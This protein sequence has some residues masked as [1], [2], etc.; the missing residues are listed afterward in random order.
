MWWWFVYIAIYLLMLI[1]GLGSFSRKPNG[2]MFVA[3]ETVSG[4]YFITIISI[5]AVTGG[6]GFSPWWVVPAAILIPSDCYMSL[7]VCPREIAIIN[8]E[9]TKG[10]LEFAQIF[11][12]LFAFPAYAAAALLFKA[13]ISP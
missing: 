2:A 9:A 1:I 10:E 7:K 12:I 3:Y 8:P 11:S 13:S 5:Y 6:I 4:A